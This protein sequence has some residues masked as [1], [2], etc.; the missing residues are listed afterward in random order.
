[1]HA[2][3]YR[4][5]IVYVVLIAVGILGAVSDAILNHWAKVNKVGWLFAAYVSW[6]IVA[7]LLGLILK[8]QYFTFSG[9]VVLFLLVN[10]A[11]AIFLDHKLFS[12]RLTAWEWIGICLAL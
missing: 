2:D 12:G 8:W 3:W 9:A 1:M 11:A 4:T 10:S 5:V 6:I 7:T